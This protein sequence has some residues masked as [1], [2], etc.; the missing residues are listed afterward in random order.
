MHLG[1]IERN[2]VPWQGVRR[3]VVSVVQEGEP[4]RALKRV[5][6]TAGV[7]WEGRLGS[8][9]AWEGGRVIE[10]VPDKCGGQDTRE[11]GECGE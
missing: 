9:T 5:Y 7:V 6:F 10:C 8:N 4:P 11:C 2:F 1:I 3:V